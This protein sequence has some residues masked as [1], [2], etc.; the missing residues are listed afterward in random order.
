MPWCKVDIRSRGLAPRG[1]EDAATFQKS[2][3]KKHA[4]TWRSFIEFASPNRSSIP[5]NV[6]GISWIYIDAWHPNVFFPPKHGPWFVR[7]PCHESRAPKAEYRGE[8]VKMYQRDV[9]VVCFLGIKLV[10]YPIYRFCF[11]CLFFFGL[12]DVCRINSPIL[13]KTTIAQDRQVSCCRHF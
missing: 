9:Y 13:P 11:F 1:G 10:C 7:W 8:V 6:W 4:T 5:P 3:N 12:G 2:F